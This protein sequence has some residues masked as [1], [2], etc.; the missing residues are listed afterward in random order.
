M[1]S[2]AQRH[3]GLAAISRAASCQP[4]TAV[5]SALRRRRRTCTLAQAPQSEPYQEEERREGPVQI[6]RS[7]RPQ[8]QRRPYSRVHQRRAGIPGDSA[9]G[10]G[11]AGHLLDRLGTLHGG[12]A[13]KVDQREAG[14]RSRQDSTMAEDPLAMSATLSTDISAS[15]AQGRGAVDA[16]AQEADRVPRGTAGRG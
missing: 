12:E 4:D 14:A 9:H 15:P 16:V 2:V 10:R 11:E 8:P 1:R 6:E 5:V 13:G 7:Q 3:R